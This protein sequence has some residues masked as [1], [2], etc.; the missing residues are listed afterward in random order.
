M[1]Q[2]PNL[3]VKVT[4]LPP[5]IQEKLDMLELLELENAELRAQVNN[6][7]R[8]GSVVEQPNDN[9]MVRKRI[10]LPPSGGICITINGIQYYHGQVYEFSPDQLQVV[11]EIIF[12]SWQHE[13]TIK[14]NN[15]NA[16]RRPRPG[17]VNGVTG[18]ARLLA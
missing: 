7:A 6:A 13:E 17:V 3:N 4:G 5:E 10:D 18:M 1:D 9:G 15:E 14:G 12:R 8:A 16:Y 2:K 11:N